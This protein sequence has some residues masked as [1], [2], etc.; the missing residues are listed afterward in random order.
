MLT[1]MARLEA[2]VFDA[3]R[4]AGR[5]GM[6]R[7]EIELATN[8]AGNCVRPR[9]WQLMKRGLIKPNGLTRKTASGRKAEILVA[10]DQS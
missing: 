8:L 10:H 3:I 6:T 5:D 1:H 9:V 4:S 7:D 2:M